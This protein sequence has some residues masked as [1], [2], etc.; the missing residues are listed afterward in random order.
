MLG[1][2]YQFPRP[3]PLSHIPREAPID[4]IQAGRDAAE[5]NTVA[6][7]EARSKPL[8]H[9]GVDG[10]APLLGRLLEA[11]AQILTNPQIGLDDI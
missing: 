10:D 3:R 2:R 1:G 11:A 8:R 7:I 4:I 9:F 6:L 5:L